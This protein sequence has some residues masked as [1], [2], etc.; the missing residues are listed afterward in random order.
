MD[1]KEGGARRVVI[2]WKREKRRRFTR[3]MRMVAHWIYVRRRWA[4]TNNNKC[5][6]IVLLLFVVLFGSM[7]KQV[8]LFNFICLNDIA[9]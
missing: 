7:N 6:F 4:R 5:W 3:S 1:T 8:Y 9:T 2:D